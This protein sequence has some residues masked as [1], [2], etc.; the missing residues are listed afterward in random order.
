MSIRTSDDVWKF[1]Q[2]KGS[3]LLVLL[4]IAD[5]A[6]EETREA[7]P[8]LAHIAKKTRLSARAVNYCLARLME[9]GELQ[10][11]YNAGPHRCNLF[12]LKQYEGVQSVLAKDASD[13]KG[14][15]KIPQKRVQPGAPKP[16][17][18]PSVE[19]SG[20]TVSGELPLEASPSAP[21][22]FIS[23]PLA[24]GKTHDVTA[25][26]VAGYKRDFPGVDVEQALRRIRRWNDDNPRQRKTP[27]GIRNHIS[28]WLAKDQNK[29][30]R[31]EGQRPASRPSGSSDAP[32]ELP[33]FTGREF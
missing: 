2:A 17:V 24:G 31:F 7:Y 10:I 11:Q 5:N 28:T 4:A 15:C 1:S 18:E 9:L 29:S 32:P 22:V 33:E 13:A 30:P 8:S 25:D 12:T 20:I 3:D 6:D 26:D 16:S 14:G 21:S 23:I 19:P 27:S